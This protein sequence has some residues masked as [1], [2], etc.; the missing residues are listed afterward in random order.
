MAMPTLVACRDQV[1]ERG[2][3]E[4]MGMVRDFG[5][6]PRPGEGRVDGR[7]PEHRDGRD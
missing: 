3:G 6:V 2:R 7:C 5:Q 4:S 1:E